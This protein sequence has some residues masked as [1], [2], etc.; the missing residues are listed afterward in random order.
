MKWKKTYERSWTVQIH[1]MTKVMSEVSDDQNEAEDADGEAEDES[2][3][4]K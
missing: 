1:T 2:P 3:P 4:V